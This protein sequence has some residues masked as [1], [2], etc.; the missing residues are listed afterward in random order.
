MVI[1]SKM[2]RCVSSWQYK[3]KAG[4]R[5]CH[6]SMSF[7]TKPLKKVGVIGDRMGSSGPPRGG[8]GAGHGGGLF[9]GPPPVSG[10]F[11]AAPVTGPSPF[12]NGGPPGGGHGAGHGGGLFGGPP[13]VSGLFGAAP[14][15][16][17]SP[18]TNEHGGQE[19]DHDMDV[20]M[21]I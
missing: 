2:G 12:T 16:G 7:H 11:G 6:G 1:S 18:F 17:P 13:P 3:R 15:T 5:Q 10:L 4:N 8:H 20:D 19:K 9:G 21:D 14:A